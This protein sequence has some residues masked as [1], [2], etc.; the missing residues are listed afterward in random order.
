MLTGQKLTG[1]F[2]C[3][4]DETI[5]LTGLVK[6]MGKIA[7]RKAIIKLNPKTDRENFNEAEFPFA[8][9]TFMCSNE[10]IKSAGMTFTPLLRGLT[11]D[12]KNYYE[13][14]TR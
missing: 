12:Y 8:N 5:T 7:G 14:N 13:K 9:E 6:E 1:A 11:D 2:N 3:A 4:G 10:K